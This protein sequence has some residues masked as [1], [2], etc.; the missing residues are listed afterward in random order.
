MNRLM[1]Y[2]KPLCGI[3]CGFLLSG[4]AAYVGGDLK[5]V[6]HDTY[7]HCKNDETPYRATFASN[8]DDRRANPASV[9]SGWTLG[10]IP[11]YWTHSVHSRATLYRD[12]EIIG[13]HH[14]KSHI[15]LFYGLIWPLLLDDSGV[16]AISATPELGIRS[17]QGVRRRTLAKAMADSGLAIAATDICYEE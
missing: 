10:L 6:P 16:N 11:T 2:G 9:I 12:D 13:S 4:C 8:V 1:K 15:Q 17:E 5:D 3:L 7:S 14:Y